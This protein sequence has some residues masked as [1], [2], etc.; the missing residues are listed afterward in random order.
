MDEDLRAEEKN[1]DYLLAKG[2]DFLK[3]KNYLGALSALSFAIKLSPNYAELYLR[4]SEVHMLAGN[5]LNY[6]DSSIKT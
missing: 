4:R 1:P 2:L 5:T 6:T 3:H